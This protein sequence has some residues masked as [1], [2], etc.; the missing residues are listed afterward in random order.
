MIISP[1]KLIVSCTVERGKTPGKVTCWGKNPSPPSPQGGGSQ[2]TDANQAPCH[3]ESWNKFVNGTRAQ[4][5][6]H[7]WGGWGGAGGARPSTGCGNTVNVATIDMQE[8]TNVSSQRAHLFRYDRKTPPQKE[9]GVE[10]GVRSRQLLPQGLNTQRRDGRLW[11]E[12]VNADAAEAMKNTD[13]Q[14]SENWRMG[15]QSRRRLLH[16]GAHSTLSQKME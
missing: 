14:T 9:Q 6:S 16:S 8:A 15:A 2:V 13:R 1:T 12:L 4:T 7:L 11:P 3:A 10:F 5:P